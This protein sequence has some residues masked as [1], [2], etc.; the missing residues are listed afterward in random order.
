MHLLV[1]VA[2]AAIGIALIRR[3]RPSDRRDSASSPP[4][5][6]LENAPKATPENCNW[7]DIDT[8]ILGVQCGGCDETEGYGAE[9]PGLRTC[10]IC[11]R[12]I[13][14]EIPWNEF[15]DERIESGHYH[16]VGD[17]RT[18]IMNDDLGAAILGMRPR[19]VQLFG[20]A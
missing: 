14:L 6:G 18:M 20:L 11:G 16:L 17:G 2:V 5:R 15:V 10:K 19:M 4:V 8:I 13:E 7:Q 3:R 9:A 12:R 1:L